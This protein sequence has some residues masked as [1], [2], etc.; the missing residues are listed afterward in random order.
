MGGAVAEE[1]LD[2]GWT[3]DAAACVGAEGEVEPWVGAFAGARARR[4]GG[5]VLIAVAAGVEGG[6]VIYPIRGGGFSVGKLTGFHFADDDGTGVDETLDWYGVFRGRRI[7]AIPGSVTVAG[8][9]ASNVIDIFDSESDA[10]E[11]FLGGWR[12]V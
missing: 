3:A 12:V 5:R 4:G 10:S 1:A 7:E 2:L 9:D 8:L 6:V 11:W